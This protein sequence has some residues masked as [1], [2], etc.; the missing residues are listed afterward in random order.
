MAS[1][2]YYIGVETK[3]I[4]ALDVLN[5]L[6]QAM[7]LERSMNGDGHLAPDTYDVRGTLG[8]HMRR[9]LAKVDR[10]VGDQF[11]R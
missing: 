9:L 6:E 10:L 7:K 4:E 5:E 11:G 1:Q 2:M 3:V 8:I